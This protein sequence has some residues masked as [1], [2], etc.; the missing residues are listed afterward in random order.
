MEKPLFSVSVTMRRVPIVN[1]WVSEKWELAGVEPDVGVNAITCTA[2]AGDAWLWRGFTLD[3]HPSEGEGYFLNLSAPDPRVFVMWRWEAWEG[4]ETARPWV[5][6]V[7]YHEAARMLDGGET[8]DSVP[9]PP[10]VRAW[11]EPWL[12]ANYKP[13]PRRKRRRNQD[14][15]GDKEPSDAANEGRAATPLAGD[16]PASGEATA[17]ADYA[18]SPAVHATAGGTS[19]Q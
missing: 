14:F 15:W 18:T 12:A 13:E 5:T 19:E 7:S 6:T 3:L 2:L 17:P 1:R 11:M 9:I 4:V 8:V 10:A 16:P